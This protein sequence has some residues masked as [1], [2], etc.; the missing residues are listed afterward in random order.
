MMLRQ[1]VS[2][3]IFSDCPTVWDALYSETAAVQ[4]V[5]DALYTETADV[6]TLWDALSTETD[7][8]RCCVH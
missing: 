4:T 6:Q 3:C 8:V 2:W 1:D 7:I 5:W